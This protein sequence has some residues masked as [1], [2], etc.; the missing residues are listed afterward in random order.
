[1]SLNYLATRFTCSWPWSI[2][3]ML[4]DGRVVCGCADPYAKRVLGDLRTTSLS[5]DLARA[6][7]ECAPHRPERRRIELL[8]RLSAQASPRRRSAGADPRSRR[9]AAAQPAVHRVHGGLQH[10]VLPGV[11]RT[12]DRHHAIASGGDARLGRVHESRRRSRPFARADRLLQLRRS[13]SSQA[14]RRDVRVHQDEVPAHLS[15]HEHQRP[16][17]ERREGAPPRALRHRRGDVLDRRRV[18]GD[19]TRGI[20]SAASSTSPSPTCGRW[21]TKRRETGAT[22]RN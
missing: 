8:R 19:A 13:V 22:C 12:G 5:R 14:R 18:A 16:G 17:A 6:D 9:R 2:A 15:L 20:A 11:L 7:G 3:V 10:L 21:P 1:M 4:C